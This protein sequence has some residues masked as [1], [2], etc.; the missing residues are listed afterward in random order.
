MTN[1]LIAAARSLSLSIAL[2][3]PIHS[4]ESVAV[5]GSPYARAYVQ[6]AYVAYYGRP[7]DPAGQDYWAARMDAEGGSLSA[8]I[9]AFGNSDEFNR[10]YGGLGYPELIAQIYQQ[11]LARN[12]DQGGLDYYVAELTA[13]RRTLQAI[14]LDVL[15]G[16]TGVDTLTVNNRLNVASYFTDQV[17]AGCSYGG[18]LVGVNTLAAVTSE[19]DTVLAAKATI[20][21]RCG[22]PTA[23]AECIPPQS[24]PR[25]AGD[26]AYFPHISGRIFA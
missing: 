1:L 16:A 5:T 20:D 18:E 19:T 12:P 13:G 21:G 15:N 10:R 3:L 14:T 4:T 23:F 24:I 6:K 22:I 26:S 7:A 17:S 8:I 2:I 11:T 25:A 9:G